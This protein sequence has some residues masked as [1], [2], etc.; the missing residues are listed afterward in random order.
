VT[1]VASAGGA[2]V[3]GLTRASTRPSP[4]PAPRA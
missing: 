1:I 4:E 2:V 3:F